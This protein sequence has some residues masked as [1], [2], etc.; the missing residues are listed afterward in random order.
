MDKYYKIYPISRDEANVEVKLDTNYNLNHLDVKTLD[1]LIGVLDLLGFEDKTEEDNDY[2]MPEMKAVETDF[3]ELSN[4]N[5]YAHTKDIVKLLNNAD[6]HI[7]ELEKDLEFTTKIANELIEI[8]HKLE[9]ELA[10]LKSKYEDCDKERLEN[11]MEYLTMKNN[12]LNSKQ[13]L[14]E[15][16]KEIERL[17][18]ELEETN[19]GYD[20]TYEQSSEAIKELKQNQTQLAIQELE[21]VKEKIDCEMA[22]RECDISEQTADVC[23]LIADQIDNQIK[24]LKG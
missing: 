6:K 20:F 3:M 10:K 24:E 21:K 15:K 19:A 12:W 23:V 17:K 9:Q 8:K 5:D 11:R 1:N 18:Q 2:V 13:Q 22:I 16:Y 7:A 14:A 4:I